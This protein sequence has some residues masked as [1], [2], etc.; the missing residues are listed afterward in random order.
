M[1]LQ[2][3]Q[4][5]R[6]FQV[7]M[8]EY[9]MGLFEVIFYGV[10]YPSYPNRNNWHHLTPE[11]CVL[12]TH[13][14]RQLGIYSIFFIYLCCKLLTG[15]WVS[16]Q[17]IPLNHRETHVG[18]GNLCTYTGCRGRMLGVCYGGA[19]GAGEVGGPDAQDPPVLPAPLAELPGPPPTAAPPL[20]ALAGALRN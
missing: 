8:E 6:I 16:Q 13:F 4:H 12:K 2:G 11:D 15:M 20:P 18:I 10:A 7:N 3:I 14:Q 1:T 9:E 5:P 19:A 17:F